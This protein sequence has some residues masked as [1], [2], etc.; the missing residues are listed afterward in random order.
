MPNRLPSGIHPGHDPLLDRRQFLSVFGRKSATMMV[1][2]AVKQ[3]LEEHSA[4]EEVPDIGGDE[5]ILMHKHVPAFHRLAI[6]SLF[7]KRVHADASHF[8][9]ITANDTCT[10]C[11]SC[12]L[13]CPTGALL[14]REQQDEVNLEYRA[15]A[16]IGCGLCVSICPHDALQMTTA[17]D[18]DALREDIHA[19]LFHSQQKYCANCGERYL[20]SES[21]GDYC[22]HCDNEKSI[23]SQWNGYRITGPMDR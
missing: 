22:L 18:I 10:G 16:C 2:S 15:L 1:P 17:R 3:L 11:Q 5:Q 6:M 9:A 13:R 12:A 21:P 20:V 14:W 19:T 8:H 7:S 23:N 4:P